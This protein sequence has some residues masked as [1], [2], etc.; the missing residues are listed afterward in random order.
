MF[1]L[2]FYSLIIQQLLIEE[3]KP[4]SCHKL[5]MRIYDDISMKKVHKMSLTLV[6]EE[7]SK[8]QNTIKKV[9]VT[10]S[11]TNRVCTV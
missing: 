3:L 5:Y 7:K 10:T 6:M 1:V 8:Q 11:M 4:Y 9:K 2:S